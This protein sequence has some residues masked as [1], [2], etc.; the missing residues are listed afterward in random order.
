MLSL[1]TK[2]F[3]Y[4]NNFEERVKG[5]A[6]VLLTYDCVGFGEAISLTNPE[7]AFI[8][9]FSIRRRYTVSSYI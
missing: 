5:H 8:Q 4:R 3:L 7:S 9:A 1:E 6:D 2:T